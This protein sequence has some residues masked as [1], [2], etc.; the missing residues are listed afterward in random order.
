MKVR[1]LLCVPV[2]YGSVRET[3][4]HMGVT[5][6]RLVVATVFLGMCMGT[7]C[8]SGTGAGTGGDEGEGEGEGDIGE[9]EGE[10]AAPLLF[11]ALCTSNEQCASGACATSASDLGARPFCSIACTVNNGDSELCVG[12]FLFPRCTDD[13]GCAGLGAA[14][15]CLP[16]GAGSPDGVCFLPLGDGGDCGT[17]NE[18]PAGE[19]CSLFFS[20]TGHR[21]L[22]SPSEKLPGGAACD[23]NAL[24][25]QGDLCRQA[26][27]CPDGFTCEVQGGASVCVAPPTAQCEALICWE[28]NVCAGGCD[29]D[30]T[31]P[32]GMVCEAF[33]LGQNDV[34]VGFCRP[35]S[36]S[37]VSCF[38]DSDCAAD[39][40]CGFRNNADGVEELRCQA[41]EAND[42]AFLEPCGDDPT[43]AQVE[44]TLPCAT[45][46]CLVDGRCDQICLVSTDCPDDFG[47]VFYDVIDG[48]EIGLCQQGAGCE[49]DADC[50]AGTTCIRTLDGNGGLESYC[51]R[52]R[53]GL[54]Q[55]DE[56]SEAIARGVALPQVTCFDDAICEANLDGS[57]CDQLQHTCR[58]PDDEVCDFNCIQGRCTS[59]CAQDSDCGDATEWVCSGFEVELG[60]GDRAINAS[61]RWLP[62][63]RAPCTTSDTCTDGEVCRPWVELD[64]TVSTVCATAVGVASD[65]QTCGVIGNDVVRCDND[66]CLRV[67]DVSECTSLCATNADCRGGDVCRSVPVGGAAQLATACQVD[68]GSGGIP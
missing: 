59:L 66:L 11:G 23:K 10:G 20:G 24:D 42:A 4:T 32:E 19:V 35:Q 44:D 1:S 17:T 3:H 53:G 51:V 38:I 68:D 26:A 50:G 43:T 15:V 49:R 7:G 55:G 12:G 47:C 46:I 28:H 31:C 40:V 21:W 58:A 52:S 45:D 36:G 57:R 27:D 48:Q 54:Q 33:P 2:G 5:M 16:G 56:C 63:S 6:L 30:S 18:C 41:V 14:G 37:G 60:G 67:D 39:E 34:P 9:G 25:R 8:S 65:G 61:C 13:D 62:G 29:V 64:G 22:C